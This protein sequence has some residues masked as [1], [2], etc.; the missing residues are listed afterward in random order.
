M[1]ENDQE[2]LSQ[3]MQA[4]LDHEDEMAANDV[5]TKKKK[6]KD[7][8]APPPAKSSYSFFLADYRPKLIENNPAAQFAAI[9]KLLGSTW[10]EISNDEKTKYKQMAAEDK[11]RFEKETAEYNANSG[12]TA[13][14]D[15]DA[16]AAALDKKKKKDKNAPLKPRNRYVLFCGKT[17]PKL[18]KQFPDLKGIE[19]SDKLNEVYRNLS[20]AEK[21]RYGEMVKED[22]VRY[23]QQMEEYENTGRFTPSKELEENEQG[24]Q[25]GAEVEPEVEQNTVGEDVEGK[26]D[27]DENMDFHEEGK[28]TK[29]GDEDAGEENKE[30]NEE[31]KGDNEEDDDEDEGETSVPKTVEKKKK[32]SSK[33][34]ATASEKEEAKVVITS[35]SKEKEEPK[36]KSQKSTSSRRKRKSKATAEVSDATPVS[37]KKKRKSKRKKKNS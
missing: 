14:N 33:E 19:I 1:L 8:N 23:T 24:D 28:K 15:D 35:S 21:D 32:S 5:T 20:E 3:A 7:P 37:S 6:K 17:R 2:A 22:K 31:E 26:K 12:S 16:D 4:I 27:E 29:E 18:I 9:S 11:I 10:K 30:G 13:D 36:Q 25:N 34:G